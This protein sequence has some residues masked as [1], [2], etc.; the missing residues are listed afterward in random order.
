MVAEQGKGIISE[1]RTFHHYLCTRPP[2]DRK[3]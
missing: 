3:P 1:T 2:E